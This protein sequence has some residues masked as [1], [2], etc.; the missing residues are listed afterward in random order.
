MPQEYPLV[1]IITATFNSLKFFEETKNSVFAEGMDDFEWI[2]IDDASTDG[3]REYLQKLTDQRVKLHLKETNMGMGDSYKRGVELARGKYFVILD[4]DDTVPAGSLTK[5]INLLE[6]N[7]LSNV[8]FG[9]VSYMDEHSHIYK[10][11]HFP[12][13]KGD[14]VLSPTTV[15]L[16]IFWVPSYPLKQGCVL[17]RTDFVKKNRG[18][19]DIALFLQAA[20]SGPTVFIDA[21]CLN[22]R[23]FRDQYSSSPNKRVM[24][25]LRFHWVKFSL[26]FLPWY[27][28]PFV[29]IYRTSIE[30]AK[31][32]WCYISPKR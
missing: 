21:P 3:T 9:T 13:T 26:R 28:S 22:Y 14:C 6:R 27:V 2:I 1:S 15:L 12:F 25:F 17:L 11:T 31:V 24:T 4:H 29:A 10:Q 20:T 7:P 18:I 8:A 32:L 19:F 16:A 5:R 23:T 30:F